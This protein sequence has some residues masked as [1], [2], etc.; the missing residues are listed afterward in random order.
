VSLGLVRLAIGQRLLTQIDRFTSSVPEQVNLAIELTGSLRRWQEWLG[1]SAESRSE[2]EDLALALSDWVRLHVADILQE[3]VDYGWMVPW[4]TLAPIL[5]FLLL[6]QFATFRRSTLRVLPRGHLRW[7]GGE[8]LQEV[9]SVLAGYV[10]AQLLSCLI[11]AVMLSAGLATLRVP[12]ALL[13][14]VAGGALEFVPLIGPV[15]TA[16]LTV[17]LVR[18]PRL[19]VV[20]I[21]LVAV[22]VVQDTVVYPRLI[23]RR[24]H[25]PA[26]AVLLAVWLGA[27]STGILG[28]LLAVPVVAVGAVAFR[29][30]RDYRDIERLVR[31]HSQAREAAGTALELTEPD[32]QRVADGKPRE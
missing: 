22:R 27:V 11:V 12:Y 4:L 28:V 18:G 20:L 6:T 19:L 21:F 24:V 30:W 16:L 25:L 9:N 23:G 1:W 3:A 29:H 15:A 17:G 13:I 32:A 7:R 10:R 5:S 31:A 8:F 26:V 2:L 14:G